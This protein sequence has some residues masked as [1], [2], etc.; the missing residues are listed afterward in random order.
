[1]HLFVALLALGC[2]N[3]ILD[4]DL[5]IKKGGYIFGNVREIT[6]ISSAFD[7]ALSGIP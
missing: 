2:G 7:Q 3:N 4:Q 5:D 1:M 6:K